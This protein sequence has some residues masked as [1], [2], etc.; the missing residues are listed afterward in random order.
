MSQ[1]NVEEHED[2]TDHVSQNGLSIAGWLAAV[3]RVRDLKDQDG[4][5]SDRG[6]NLNR[7]A[8]FVRGK[9]AQEDMLADLSERGVYASYLIG[10]LH[11]D[12]FD[13]YDGPGTDTPEDDDATTSSRQRIVEDDK[14]YRDL[15]DIV[16]R[17]LKHIQKRWKELRSDEGVRTAMSIPA[18]KKVAEPV[19]R[20]TSQQGSG[21]AWAPESTSDRGRE[22]TEELDQARSLGF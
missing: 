11:V 2:R 1:C 7:I 22:R 5:G 20:R 3:R 12:D 13:Q 14:R 18:V 9:L 4:A 17:E 8:I 15:Q 16:W 19:A 10:E 6:D 21:L